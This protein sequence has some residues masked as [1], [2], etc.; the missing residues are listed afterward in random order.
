MTGFVIVYKPND[1][2]L[3]KMSES[4]NLVL[5]EMI[6]TYDN[7]SKAKKR[8]YLIVLLVLYNKY[9]FKKSRYHNQYFL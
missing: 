6:L 7:E 2:F 9:I 8:N 5:N 3:R 4:T 1:M